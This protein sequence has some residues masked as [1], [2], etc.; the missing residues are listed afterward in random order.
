MLK[1]L[2]V[3]V[4]DENRM[5]EITGSSPDRCT[6][7]RNLIWADSELEMFVDATGMSADPNCGFCH[8]PGADYADSLLTHDC[9]I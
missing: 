8:E 6:H 7:C 5:N 2:R 9:A 4:K 1:R 3:S